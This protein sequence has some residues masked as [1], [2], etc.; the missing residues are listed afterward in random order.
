MRLSQS[1]PD[2][3][4]KKNNINGKGMGDIAIYDTA[5]AVEKHDGNTT[6]PKDM[7]WEEEV[8]I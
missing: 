3:I 1:R 5:K 6:L 2:K 7:Q 8:D 4:K